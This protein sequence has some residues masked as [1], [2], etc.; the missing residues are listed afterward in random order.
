MADRDAA[1]LTEAE[2]EELEALRAE[3]A[4]REEEEA[5]R[6]EREELEALR[7]EQEQVDAEILRERAEEE[8]PRQAP[9]RAAEP[10][11]EPDPVVDPENLTFG[12]RMVMTPTATDSDDIP[13]MAPA[14]KIIIG[15][16]LI[17]VVL[18]AIY[19]FTR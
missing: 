14:Q 10:S 8:R 2:R 13:V 3:K 6:A 17:G 12:Q 7:S 9:A 18:L 5:A 4:R 15:L 1:P 11:P 16:A 19:I